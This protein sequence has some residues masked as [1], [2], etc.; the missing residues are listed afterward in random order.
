[1]GLKYLSEDEI[2]CGDRSTHLRFKAKAIRLETIGITSK[3]K[4]MYRNRRIWEFTRDEIFNAPITANRY[5][6]WHRDRI[7]EALRMIESKI[8]E[9]ENMFVLEEFRGQGIGV[10][11]LQEFVTWCKSKDVKR[12]RTV[13]SAQ[14]TRAIEFYRR[15]GFLDYDLVLERDL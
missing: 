7:D 13:A 9:A 1:M 15:A 8:A 12:I 14:N 5:T 6:Q 2:Y 4:L 11:L 3:L 10:K